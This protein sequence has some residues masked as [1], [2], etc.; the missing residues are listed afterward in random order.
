M[1]HWRPEKHENPYKTK[2]LSKKADPFAI[3]NHWKL[4]KTISKTSFC[5]SEGNPIFRKTL[6]ILRK[7]LYFDQKTESKNDL[8]VAK[9][10]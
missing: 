9:P 5:E 10:L 2:G 7:T 1:G 3:K 4:L 6:E 8:K